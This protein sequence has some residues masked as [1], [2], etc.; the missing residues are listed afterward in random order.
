[1]PVRVKVNLRSLKGSKIGQVVET[2]ALLNTGYT[3]SSPEIIIPLKLAERLGLWPLFKDIV[4]SIYDT[5]GGPAKFYVIRE[6]VTLK[7]VEED[8]TSREL[9]TDTVISPME[10]EV[11]LS[12]YVIGEL[13]IVILNAYTGIWRFNNDPIEKIRYTKRPELW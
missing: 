11:L 4:E 2:S 10:R 5:A 9:I 13:G 12:D 7:I 1:M 6:G 8:Y 3:G